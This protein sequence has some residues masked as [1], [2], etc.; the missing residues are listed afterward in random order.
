MPQTESRDP[1]KAVAISTVAL[2][3]ALAC[4][5]LSV[6]LAGCSQESELPAGVATLVWSE[7]Q[8]GKN[9][10]PGIDQ[11]SIDCGLWSGGG[12][13][14]VVWTDLSNGGMEFLPPVTTKKEGFVFV[15]HHEGP[16][17]R[18]N[19]CRCETRDGIT[20]AV[21]INEKTFDLA[22]GALFLVSTA[23]GQTHVRQL[24]RDTHKLKTEDLKE[25]AKNNP[26][27]RGFFTD[28]TQ[29]TKP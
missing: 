17:G 28:V 29:T 1:M 19:D 15:G 27:I 20:G 12:M 21:T 4:S 11:A 18:H 3:S 7:N 2:C 6:G 16:N 24:K 10:V 5:C 8:P 9:P 22:Q 25:L 14:V 23:S 13:A 26:E